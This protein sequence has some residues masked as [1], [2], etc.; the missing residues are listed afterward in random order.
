MDKATACLLLFDKKKYDINA[1]ATL[2]GNICILNDLQECIKINLSGFKNCLLQIIF[3]N[4]V[5][6]IATSMYK[7]R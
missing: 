1:G 7:Y 4:F 2:A 6:I 5:S 3:C